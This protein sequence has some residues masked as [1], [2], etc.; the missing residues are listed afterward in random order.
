M[1]SRGTAFALHRTERRIGETQAHYTSNPELRSLETLL[2][3]LGFRLQ[4]TLKEAN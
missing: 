4:A 3:M 1:P 2:D